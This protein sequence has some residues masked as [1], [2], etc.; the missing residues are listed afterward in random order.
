MN[1]AANIV[2]LTLLGEYCKVVTL[3]NEHL[4]STNPL[5]KTFLACFQALDY[6]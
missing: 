3:V 6:R 4:V 1:K 5:S 2:S